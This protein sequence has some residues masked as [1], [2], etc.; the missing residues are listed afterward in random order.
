MD[1]ANQRLVEKAIQDWNRGDLP[2]YMQL[3]SHDVII[4]G[5]AGLE[6]GF[7]NVQRFY[8]RWWQGFPGS[9]LILHDMIGT[10]DR[11]ACRVVIEGVHSG[12]FQGV[13]ASGRPI[14]VSTFTILRFADGHCVERWSLADS[15]AL[16]TQIGALRGA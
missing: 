16:L 2:A 11:I 6:P 5:Y 8:E 13:P 10:G 9:Q 12:P 3:Y 15:L 14:S 7:D 4:H 1:R